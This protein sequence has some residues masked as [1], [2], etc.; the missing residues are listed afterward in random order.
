ML[1]TYC[2]REHAQLEVKSSS[3]TNE[4]SVRPRVLSGV[5]TVPL[6]G[7]LVVGNVAEELSSAEASDVGLSAALTKGKLLNSE[8][9]KNVPSHLSHLPEL[10][11]SDLVELIESN[12]ISFADV[13]SQTNLLK[14]DIDVGD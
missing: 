1:Q 9:L 13:P 5:K 8:I 3:E 6:P 12:Q 2:E 11:C 14:H 10:E 4:A 7:S